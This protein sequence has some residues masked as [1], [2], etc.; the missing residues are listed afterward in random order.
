M[1]I[2]TLAF[3]WYPSIFPQFFH[4]LLSCKQEPEFPR[5]NL[6]VHQEGLPGKLKEGNFSLYRKSRICQEFWR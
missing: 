4:Q 5:A 3:L 6:A 1:K 2:Y